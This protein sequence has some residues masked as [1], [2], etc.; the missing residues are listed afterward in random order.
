MTTF[1]NRIARDFGSSGRYEISLFLMPEMM[2]QREK[3]MRG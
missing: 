1:M 3:V 2:R